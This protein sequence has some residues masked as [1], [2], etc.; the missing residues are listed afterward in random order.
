MKSVFAVCLIAL[1]F[2][3]MWGT[4]GYLSVQKKQVQKSVK[5]KMM[6]GIPREEL[7]YFK[8]SQEDIATKLNWKHAKEFEFK[9][10]MYDIVERNE[11]EDSAFYWVWWDKE[12]TVHNQ[13]VKRQ[14]Q[15]FL[16]KTP[17]QQKQQQFLVSFYQSLFCEEVITLNNNHH[18]EVT[19]NYF[20]DQFFTFETSL[21]V[22][23]P[24]PK[25]TF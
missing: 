2:L 5:R 13:K 1:L 7:I 6:E 10:E 18:T 23:G 4:F 24:P 15:E 17:D 16:G 20:N 12:E 22:L 14:A 21:D 9:G 8:F 19:D 3:P 11:T 25:F